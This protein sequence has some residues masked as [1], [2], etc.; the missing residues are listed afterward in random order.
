MTLDFDYLAPLPRLNERKQDAAPQGPVETAYEK[1]IGQLLREAL[2]VSAI[3]PHE[4]FLPL[5]QLGRIVTHSRVRN[6]LE[7]ALGRPSSELAHKIW[8]IEH[9]SETR[10][11]SRRKL[12]AIMVRIGRVRDVPKI[13]A[14]G[15]FDDD[16]P[17]ELDTSNEGLP[18][19]AIRREGQL[20]KLTFCENWANMSHEYFERTQWAVNAPFLTLQQSCVLSVGK[21]EKRHLVLNQH[22]VLPII[23]C[24]LLSIRMFA[25]VRQVQ[26]HPDHHVLIQPDVSFQYQFSAVSFF[27]QTVGRI[28]G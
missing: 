21:T 5:G 14:E 11:T 10:M 23:S 6:E 15:L 28:I 2:I 16:L 22:D 20:R 4:K 12:F 27:F 1:P 7:L 19:L 3:R 13:I 24:Q 9:L 18:F 25:D 8:D 26:F 17:F